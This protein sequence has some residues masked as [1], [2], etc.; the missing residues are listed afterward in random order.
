MGGLRIAVLAGRG[1]TGQAVIAALQARAERTGTSVDAVPIGRVA[2]DELPDRLAGCGAVYLIAP[3]M[4]PDEPVYAAG[5]LDAARAAGVRR[6]VLHSVAAPHAPAMPHH[7]G[8]A[9]AEDL[10]RRWGGEWSILQ[11]GAYLQNFPLDGSP[12]QVAY[13][14]AARFGFADLADLAEVAATVLVDDD[15]HGATYELA[16]LTASVT[17]LA[18]AVGAP[19]EQ[20]SP[21]S[22]AAGPGASLEPRV[23]EWLLAM[24][25]YYDHF[26]LPV[27]TLPMR[28]LL[29]RAPTT[30]T[31]LG[32]LGAS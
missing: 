29:G 28:T 32:R 30:L 7:L 24:F 9:R 5:V 8:K 15:H 2:S 12:I 21:E 14:P 17:E 26:G 20:V 1:K 19:L 27:G 11:P 16:S 25:D 31:T 3:N 6:V 4:H 18:T 22:W 23:R 10:V 13:D